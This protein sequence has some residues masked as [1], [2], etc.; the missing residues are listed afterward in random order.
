MPDRSAV[1]RAAED[2]RSWVADLGPSWIARFDQIHA[3][4]RRWAERVGVDPHS[5]EFRATWCVATTFLH[6]V[7]RSLGTGGAEE[8][9]DL[10]R[11][12]NMVA[13]AGLWG[14]D[15][16]GSPEL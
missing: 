4:V 9:P 8:G 6:R 15:P 2:A 1:D 14:P 10:S 11:L 16:G 3:D 7:A 5:Y 12:V 13:T